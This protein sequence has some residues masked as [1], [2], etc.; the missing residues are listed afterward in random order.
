M[1]V[2]RGTFTNIIDNFLFKTPKGLNDI[3]GMKI[4]L[5]R[6]LKTGTKITF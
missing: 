2:K 4:E 1:S 6:E 5:N 3:P